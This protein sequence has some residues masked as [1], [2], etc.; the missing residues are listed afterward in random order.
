METE[1]E[2]VVATV[3]TGVD[4]S[5]S[6]LI[7]DAANNAV[8]ESISE[9]IIS[10]TP[11][12]IQAAEYVM[13]TES[14]TPEGQP[15][16]TFQEE[17]VHYTPMETENVHE[18]EITTHDTVEEVSTVQT[19]PEN[20]TNEDNLDNETILEP[21]ANIPEE[22]SAE[23][24]NSVHYEE[25]KPDNNST[26]VFHTEEE[27]L[28]ES[29]PPPYSSSSSILK[30]VVESTITSEPVITTRSLFISIFLCHA[31]YQI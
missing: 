6:F 20:T 14:E 31:L 13:E 12:E 10:Q 8:E 21:V 30:S 27:A 16:E 18:T 3:E 1:T 23:V 7:P 22:I 9:E 15:T 17:T 24:T 4:M 19:I 25:T 2:E 29:P 28:H 26:E 5:N 11:G